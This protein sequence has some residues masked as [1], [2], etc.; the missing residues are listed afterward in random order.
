MIEMNLNRYRLTDLEKKFMLGK[1]EGWGE[2]TVRESRTD[3]H[4]PLYLK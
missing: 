4:T 3:M 2:G 1:W